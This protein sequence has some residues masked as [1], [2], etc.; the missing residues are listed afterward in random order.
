M[1][2]MWIKNSAKWLI[3]VGGLTLC[4]AC[5]QTQTS[6]VW[7]DGYGYTPVP[8]PGSTKVVSSIGPSAGIF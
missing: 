2:I 4:S 7:D 1:K 8:L 6:T 5:A 3:A